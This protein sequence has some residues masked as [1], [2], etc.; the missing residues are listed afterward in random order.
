MAHKSNTDDSLQQERGKSVEGF[1]TNLNFPDSHKATSNNSEEDV[2]ESRNLLDKRTYIARLLTNMTRISGEVETLNA[3]QSALSKKTGEN[4]L[5]QHESMVY[6][7]YDNA[8]LDGNG[9]YDVKSFRMKQGQTGGVAGCKTACDESPSCGGFSH[10]SG[11]DTCWMKNMNILPNPP[12]VNYTKSLRGDMW[13]GQINLASGRS[14]ITNDAKCRAAGGWSYGYN[15]DTGMHFCSGVCNSGYSPYNGAAWWLGYSSCARSP[16]LRTSPANRDGRDNTIAPMTAAEAGE[17][18]D[19]YIDTSSFC[20]G[21]N[22]YLSATSTEIKTESKN[23]GQCAKTCA[24]DDTCDMYMMSNANTCRTYKNVSNV[25]SFCKSAPDHPSWGN[26]KKNMVGKIVRFPQTGG[27]EGFSLLSETD[28]NNVNH[29]DDEEDEEDDKSAGKEGF[30]LFSWFAEQRRKNSSDYVAPVPK[31]MVRVVGNC[32]TYPSMTD[33]GWVNDKDHGGPTGP[34]SGTCEYRK[35]SWIRSCRTGGNNRTRVYSKHYSSGNGSPSGPAPRHTWTTY[36]KRTKEGFQN[37]WTKPPYTKI[38]PYIDTGD[39]A[40]PDYRGVIKGG[41]E[42]CSRRC[43]GMSFFGLQDQNANGSQCFCGNDWDKATQY[44]KSSCGEGGGPWCNYIYKHRD[45]AAHASQNERNRVKRELDARLQ[46]YAQGVEDLKKYNLDL[47]RMT[48]GNSAATDTALKEYKRN[49][50]IV[51]ENRD[52][53]IWK[54]EQSMVDVTGVVR[55]SH[56]Y[57]YVLWFTLVVILLFLLL[58]NSM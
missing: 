4:I 19:K 53:Q 55:K 11:N 31:C 20:N 1:Y 14:D 50:E 48:R 44:G 27:A 38:G 35:N 57:V 52:N 47:T 28:D 54:T 10:W 29:T 41:A 30:N 58:R 8:Y 16:G 51:A 42:E 49:I 17:V 43:Q 7:K 33:S 36:V 6:D 25:S 40:L 12:V 9:W 32:G 15:K 37:G 46:E 13:D 24:D 34:S 5:S 2:L 3:R 45:T 56:A 26:L 23:E 22:I 39:R 21:E 18:K